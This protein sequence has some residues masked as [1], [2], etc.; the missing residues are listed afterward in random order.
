VTATGTVAFTPSDGIATM[1]IG[2]GSNG[3]FQL[4]DTYLSKISAGDFSFGAGG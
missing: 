2:N 4:T 3:T 1:G